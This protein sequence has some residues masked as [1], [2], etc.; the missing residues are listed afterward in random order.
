MEEAISFGRVAAKCRRAQVEMLQ[1]RRPLALGVFDIAFGDLLC[2]LHR[3]HHV[4]SCHRFS[5]AW[6]SSRSNGIRGKTAAMTFNQ[7]STLKH[8][9]SG[10]KF[11]NGQTLPQ[12][13]CEKKRMLPSSLQSPHSSMHLL[14]D[15]G[16]HHIGTFAAKTDVQSTAM[17]VLRP[18]EMTFLPDIE[19]DINSFLISRSQ[20]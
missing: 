5:T 12:S 10:Y 8:P 7:H 20:A 13:T 11:A 6:L 19:N 14:V 1:Q 18:C 3:G 2:T 15:V 16:G 9:C 17:A 4:F